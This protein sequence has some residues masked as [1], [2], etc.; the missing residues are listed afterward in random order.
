MLSKDTSKFKKSLV[1]IVLPLIS[2]AAIILDGIK[3]FQYLELFMIRPKYV[4]DFKPLNPKDDHVYVKSLENCDTNITNSQVDFVNNLGTNY[5]VFL[6]IFTYFCSV[7]SLLTAHLAN[8][9][10]C[11]S[12]ISTKAYLNWHKLSFVA[13]IFAFIFSVPAN[14]VNRIEYIDCIEL[15]GLIET[16]SSSSTKVTLNGFLWSLFI[17]PVI[18]LIVLCFCKEKDIQGDGIVKVIIIFVAVEFLILLGYIGVSLALKFGS[19]NYF[20]IVLD[21]CLILNTLNSMFV[22]CRLGDNSFGIKPFRK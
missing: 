7:I 8:I 19:I 15:N 18:F 14:F 6:C 11:R 2:V 12:K 16:F 21:A 4:H 13:S 17:I 22:L 3:T 10:M 9:F 1:C 20:K 5:Y